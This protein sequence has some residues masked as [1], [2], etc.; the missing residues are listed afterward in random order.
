MGD[1]QLPFDDSV[2]KLEGLVGFNLK[3]DQQRA[4]KELHIG[5]NF[6]LGASWGTR[7]ECDAAAGGED[8]GSPP[9]KINIILIN[10]HLVGVA[11]YTEV[12][13]D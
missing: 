13:K 3:P 1:L 12:K 6:C 10:I 8:E 5:S 9:I 4:L 2:K 7:S 11:R